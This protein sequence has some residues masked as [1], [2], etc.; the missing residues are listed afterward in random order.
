MPDELGP[1]FVK[2][3]GHKDAALLKT[4][5]HPALDFRAMT[6]GKFW[7]SESVDDIVDRIFF[8]K[9]FS[10]ADEIIEIS[11]V[12]TVPVG[13]RNRVGYRFMV[14]NPDGRHLVEQQAYY[15]T[16]GGQIRWLR[17]MCAGYLREA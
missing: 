1:Q 3:L 9:W 12:E 17:I 6:P 13:P 2:A 5:L 4:L 15:E 11:D 14:K 7:E 16:D 8:R 10:D